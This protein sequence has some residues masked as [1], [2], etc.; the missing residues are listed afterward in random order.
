MSSDFLVS[1][2]T[3][4]RVIE[5]STI[6][7][8]FRE[9]FMAW[10]TKHGAFGNN[11][12]PSVKLGMLIGEMTADSN[13]GVPI[14]DDMNT[15]FGDIRNLDKLPF[16]KLFHLGELITIASGRTL[17]EAPFVANEGMDGLR[18]IISYM[19]DGD[20]M[21]DSAVRVLAP[22]CRT[23]LL[24]QHPWLAE[25]DVSVVTPQNADAWLTEQV[26]KYGERH[27]VVA[28]V[29]TINPAES[30]SD[31]HM[32]D[33]KMMKLKHPVMKTVPIATTDVGKIF[34][35][36]IDGKS[37]SIM[38]RNEFLTLPIENYSCWEEIGEFDINQR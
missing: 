6:A 20:M 30:I 5:Q 16:V 22:T 37:G 19:T 21:T 8:Q 38:T 7:P 18:A 32:R 14:G 9:A 17:G 28:L 25:I 31:L 23:G 3:L 10:L 27:P 26:M 4:R 33:A 1:T 12:I 36:S 29:N 24:E 15:V 13:S 34:V 11:T 2:A 35:V